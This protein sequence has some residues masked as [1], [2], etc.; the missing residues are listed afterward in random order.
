VTKIVT[1]GDV[2]EQAVT[3]RLQDRNYCVENF[4]IFNMLQVFQFGHGT[5]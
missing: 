5:C 3:V 1:L 2:K 4:K